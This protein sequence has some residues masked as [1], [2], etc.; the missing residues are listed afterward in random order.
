[1]NEVTQQNRE[2]KELTGGKDLQTR[3][4]SVFAFV[5]FANTVRQNLY[6][7]YLSTVPSQ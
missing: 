1:M 2:N 6:Y 3:V 7:I 5:S 4:E